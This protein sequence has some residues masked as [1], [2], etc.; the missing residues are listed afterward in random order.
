MKLKNI[1]ISLILFVFAFNIYAQE[2]EGYP[3]N[4]AGAPR[5]K[6]LIFYTTHAEEAHVQFAQQTVEFF[7]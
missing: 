2:P 5:F 4:Y 3:A 6:A 1:V 7:W